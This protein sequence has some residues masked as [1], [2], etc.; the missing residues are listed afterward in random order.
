M[1]EIE[2][3]KEL[4]FIALSNVDESYY[5][6]TYNNIENFKMAFFHRMGRMRGNN[7]ERYG[8]RVFCYEFYHQLR[9]LID[10]ERVANVNFLNEAKLQAE[11]QKMQI[12]ELEQSLGLNPMSGAFAPDFL[13]HSPGNANS[14]PCVIEVKCEHDISSR[15]VFGD[16][17][18]LNEFIIKYNYLCG[19]FLSVNTSNEYINTLLEELEPKIQGLQGRG[20]IIVI[21]KQEQNINH[22]I[23]QL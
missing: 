16:L 2:R 4:I 12:I 19:I 11:V 21:N 6:T 5:R 3:F 7:F 8:E 13:M 14:H 9:K 23:W 22:N 10:N 20:R 18:K 15:K 1:N 17:L